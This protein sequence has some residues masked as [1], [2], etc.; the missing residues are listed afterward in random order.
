MKLCELFHD[1]PCTWP[2]VYDPE[3]EITDLVYDSAALY[4]GALLF[5]CGAPMRTAINMPPKRRKP[6]PPL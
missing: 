5:A 6:G 1:I 3:L 2:S 4:R